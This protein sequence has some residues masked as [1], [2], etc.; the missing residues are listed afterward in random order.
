MGYLLIIL[1]VAVVFYAAIPGAGAFYVRS[2]WRRFRRRIIHSSL[3]PIA[4]YRQLQVPRD[5]FIGTFRFFGGLEAIQGE[6]V[7]WLRSERV[8]VSVDLTKVPVY[9]LPSFASTQKEGREELN[10]ET[11]PDEMPSEISWRRVFSLPEGTQVFVAGPV[12][13]ENGHAV[14][15]SSK[16]MVVSMVIYDGARESILRRAIWAGRHRNEYWNPFTPGSVSVGSFALIILAYLLLR[17]PIL[18][19]QAVIALTVG[20]FPL[21]PLLPPGLLFFFAY[22]RWWKLARF[23]RAERDMVL[24]PLRHF[25]G[26]TGNERRLSYTLGNGEEIVAERWYGEAESLE[27]LGKGKIRRAARLRGANDPTLPRYLFGAP[28]EPSLLQPVDPMVE[29]VLIPG[30]PLELSRACSLQARR[31]EL[32]SASVLSVGVFMNIVMIFWVL[33]TIIR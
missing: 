1:A 15:R 17:S 2:R 11:L 21:T 3:F 10:E 23:L 19:L 24:L 4:D 29:L 5:G 25:K 16:D 30:N 13:R 22:R 6:N 8:S 32:L 9:W 7:V 31:L 12:Y 28:A 33:S 26:F 27:R 20:L 18:R 14:F